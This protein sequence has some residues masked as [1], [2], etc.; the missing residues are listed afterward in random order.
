MEGFETEDG[1]ALRSV[2]RQNS[3]QRKKTR[4]K[5]I[6]CMKYRSFDTKL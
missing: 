6:S 4:P 1:F 3:E 2:N 5:L